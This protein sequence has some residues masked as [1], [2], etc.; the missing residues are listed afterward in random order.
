LERVSP[1]HITEAEARNIQS[2]LDE[3][4]PL[5]GLQPWDVFVAAEATDSEDDDAVASVHPTEGR[6][7]AGVRIGPGWADQSAEVKRDTLVHE[8]LHLVHRDQTDIIRCGL[9]SSGYLPQPTFDLLWETFRLATEV[10]VDHLTGLLT[11]HLP[12]W[13]TEVAQP[14][15]PRT[16]RGKAS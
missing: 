3:L 5:L 11:P 14:R 6:R 2:Y 9:A 4:K 7:V 15:R 13:H 10:M 8:L 1:G 12:E 16:P